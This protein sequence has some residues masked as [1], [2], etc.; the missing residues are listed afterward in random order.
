MLT[1]WAEPIGSKTSLAFL[2][3]GYGKGVIGEVLGVHHQ[4]IYIF[5]DR[6]VLTG[7]NLSKNYFLNRRDRCISIESP[8]LSDYLYEYLQIIA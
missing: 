5:D 7:A 3:A 8:E 4:K 2:K 1:D 6:V